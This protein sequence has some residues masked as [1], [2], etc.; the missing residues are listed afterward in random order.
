MCVAAEILS[1][2][3]WQARPP[4]SSLNVR[5]NEGPKH[6]ASGKRGSLHQNH[7][8]TTSG[9]AQK[10]SKTIQHK[11]S[12]S[13]T[14]FNSKDVASVKQFHCLSAKNAKDSQASPSSSNHSRACRLIT[15][16]EH[17]HCHASRFLGTA[18][19]A[20]GNPPPTL[21]C[22]F[23]LRLSHSPRELSLG[24]LTRIAE[25]GI[26]QKMCSRRVVGS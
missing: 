14:S 17:K 23:C 11:P 26:S 20:M 24:L 2:D 6:Q 15:S 7:T 22:S 19:N 4:K 10:R 16:H 9:I 25:L 5:P 8:V 3:K 18:V 13:T 21:A 1:S 12:A